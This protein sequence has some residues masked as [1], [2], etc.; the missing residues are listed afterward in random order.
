M[1]GPLRPAEPEVLFPLDEV[2]VGPRLSEVCLRCGRHWE[3]CVCV[4]MPD[5]RRVEEKS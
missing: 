2:T 4:L 1:T 3:R 5:R